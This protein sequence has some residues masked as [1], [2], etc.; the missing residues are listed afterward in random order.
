MK[1]DLRE[2][3]AVAWIER[4]SNVLKWHT[5]VNM[6]MNLWDPQEYKISR[7]AIM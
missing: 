7:S 1:L 4:A 2:N 3:K 6:V 5:F